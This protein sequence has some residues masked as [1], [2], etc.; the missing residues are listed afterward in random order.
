MLSL[1]AVL[2]VA[3]FATAQNNGAKCTDVDSPIYSTQ[4]FCE[5]TFQGKTTYTIHQCT[6]GQSEINEVSADVYNSRFQQGLEFMKKKKGWRRD[7]FIR[8]AP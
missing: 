8:G 2:A 4:T 5:A 1:L 6:D 3:V 7:D